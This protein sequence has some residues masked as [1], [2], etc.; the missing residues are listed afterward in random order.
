MSH[1]ANGFLV[2]FAGLLR[3][4]RSLPGKVLEAR[5]R[6]SCQNPD[7]F[8]E[9]LGQGTSGF[10]AVFA[11]IADFFFTFFG[12]ITNF[13]CAVRRIFHCPGKLA[14]Y[15]LNW[16]QE[17]IANAFDFLRAFFAKICNVFAGFFNRR[18]DSSSYRLTKFIPGCLRSGESFGK[19]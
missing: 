11:H 6:Q 17:S 4:L 1:P 15:G 8:L 16:V 5:D 10:F 18:A 7:D 19:C 14:F 13:F 12:R 3:G 2:G 9:R